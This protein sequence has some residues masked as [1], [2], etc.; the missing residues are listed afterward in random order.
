[1]A[2]STLVLFFILAVIVTL[3]IGINI[4]KKLGGPQLNANLQIT[5]T[6]IYISAASRPPTPTREFLPQT[7]SSPSPV[8]KLSLA[9]VTYTDNRCA[10]SFSYPGNFLKSLT[11]NDLSVIFTHPDDP[12]IAL[13]AT[14]SEKIPLPPVR[15]EDQETISLDGQ[16]A[17]LYHDKYPD[18][19]PRDEVIVKHPANDWEIII[20]GYGATFQNSL[21]SFKFL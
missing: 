18:G 10:F 15:T 8:S 16:T 1:M 12:N 4:G 14:C 21:K 13:A 6:A 19:S 5:P 3:L 17:I 11:N 7:E 9:Q 20:A 2:K